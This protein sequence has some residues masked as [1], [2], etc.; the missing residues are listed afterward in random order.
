MVGGASNVGYAEFTSLCMANG[1][2]L[3]TMGTNMYGFGN[4][5][6]PLGLPVESELICRRPESSEG[7]E[8]VARFFQEPEV[9]QLRS[10][11]RPNTFGITVPLYSL[12]ESIHIGIERLDAWTLLR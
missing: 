3:V 7:W 11:G 12:P 1:G 6:M 5:G 2:Q 9:Q 4:A 10:T 8:K